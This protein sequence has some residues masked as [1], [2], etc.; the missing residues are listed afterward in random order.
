MTTSWI[1]ATQQLSML[2]T[3]LEKQEKIESFTKV[4]WGP[5]ESF[6]DFLQRLFS[7]VNRM[8]LN[9]EAR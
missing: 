8:I 3:E 2:M 4:I 6:M 7:A 1:F 9:S 5:K